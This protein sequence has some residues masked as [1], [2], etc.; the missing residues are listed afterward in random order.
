MRLIYEYTNQFNKNIL[1]DPISIL[2]KPLSSQVIVDTKNMFG[3]ANAL[4]TYSVNLF[5]ALVPIIYIFN[6]FYKNNYLKLKNYP[7]IFLSITPIFL[8]FFIGRDWGRWINVLSFAI[9]L[10]YLQFPLYKNFKLNFFSNKKTPTLILVKIIII[11]VCL[12]Y[13]LFMM[14]PHCCNNTN[15]HMGGFVE[16]VKMAYTILFGDFGSHLD[17]AFRIN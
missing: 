11:S 1:W 2:S 7:L 3:S 15:Y 13:L 6:N 4:K 5:F 10:L 8:L 16:N 17:N 12:Y 9:L 14:V